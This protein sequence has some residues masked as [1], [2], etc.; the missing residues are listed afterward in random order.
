M[1]KIIIINK[2]TK[3]IN[4]ILIYLFTAIPT[5]IFFYGRQAVFIAVF[6]VVAFLFFKK[7]K[8]FGNDFKTI[9]LLITVLHITQSLIFG[10][11]AFEGT[12]RLYMTF[13]YPY[14]IIK[15]I[16][17]KWTYYFVNYI[18]AITIISLLFYIPSLISSSFH[19]FVSSIAPTLGTDYLLADQNFIVYTSEAWRNGLL[20]NSGNFTEPGLFSCYLILA[21]LFHITEGTKIFNK[22]GFILMLGIISTFST[23]GYIALAILIF[24]YLFNIQKKLYAFSIV[25]IFIIF[26]IYFFNNTHFLRKKI[27]I[28][29]ESQIKGTIKNKGRFASALNDIE[30]LK[31]YPISGRGLTKSTRFDSVEYWEADNAPRS[32]T[33]GITNILL[34]FGIIGIVIYVIMLYKSIR[35]YSFKNNMNML[36]VLLSIMAIMAVAFGQTIL[37][38]P[39][40]ISL[41]FLKNLRY[42]T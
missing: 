21:L 31:K 41:L 40:F 32:I 29:Y 16:K 20:R 37:F 5:T 33:N 13:L 26:S 4:Y 42:L 17:G 28:Q 1:K 25:P 9:V 39:P 11:F 14:F 2:Q 12:V 19:S 24:I 8:V 23:A 6:L 30:D 3:V 38:N 34:K 18:V 22:K 36:F 27:E 35:Y 7:Q 10:R 15:L